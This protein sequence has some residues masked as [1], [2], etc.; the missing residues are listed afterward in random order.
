MHEMKSIAPL[1]S[2]QSD[3]L[4]L[5]QLNTRSPMEIMSSRGHTAYFSEA[6]FSGEKATMS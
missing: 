6:H 1:I 4:I 5:K 3:N 2:P